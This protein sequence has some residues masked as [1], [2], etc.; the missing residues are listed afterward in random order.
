MKDNQLGLKQHND[1]KSIRLLNSIQNAK[2]L[3]PNEKLKT[4][5]RKKVF[6]MSFTCVKNNLT[7]VFVNTFERITE[8]FLTN[9]R[10]PI[11]LHNIVTTNYRIIIPITYTN[12][13]HGFIP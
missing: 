10:M 3:V 9:S 6:V 4:G 8:K 2:P 12:T 13:T 7:A 11:V 5:R 1:Q